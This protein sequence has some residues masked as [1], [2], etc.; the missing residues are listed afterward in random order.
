MFSN[1]L[2]MVVPSLAAVLG[3]V[4]LAG[5]IVRR[6]GLASRLNAGGR[7]SV[8]QAI[9]LDQRRRLHLVRCDGRKVLLLTGGGQDVVV[10]WLDGDPVPGGPP[11][12]EVASP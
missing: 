1:P 9:A 12:P 2:W 5:R 8:V 10:G 11:G 7:I 6:T 3:L 4:L